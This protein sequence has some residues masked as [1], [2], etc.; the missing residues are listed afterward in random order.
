MQKLK[1]KNRQIPLTNFTIYRIPINY[2]LRIFNFAKFNFLIF[3]SR[4]VAKNPTKL[5]KAIPS[6]VAN[7]LEGLIIWGR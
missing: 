2:P 3:C 5:N 7:Q 6:E 4:I 1:T